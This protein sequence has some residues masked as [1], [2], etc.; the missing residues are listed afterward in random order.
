MLFHLN[1]RGNVFYFR[2]RIPKDL[3]SHFPRPE[4]RISL[5]TTN[6]SAAKL[7]FGQLEDK[8]QKSFALIRTGSVSKEQMDSIIGELCPS[9]EDVSTKTASNLSCQIDLYI[10]DRSP[11]W[12]AKTTVEFTKN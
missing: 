10:A 12:S 4:V 11:H 2:L 5:K 3:S 8:F 1:R 6:R 9:S 7:L